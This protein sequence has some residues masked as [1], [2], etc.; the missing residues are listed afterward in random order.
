MEN[1]DKLQLSNIESKLSRLISK[2]DVYERR[3]DN[4][5]VFYHR[6]SPTGTS[7]EF[8]RHDM[9]TYL[10]STSNTIG[11]RD[12]YGIMLIANLMWRDLIN[13]LGKY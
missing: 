9:Y 7:Y 12:W 5:Y 10:N 13:K 1:M 2:I 4:E 11:R 8:K 3:T 6:W